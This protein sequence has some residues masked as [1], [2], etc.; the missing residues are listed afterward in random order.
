MIFV[1]S[2]YD[3]H[4]DSFQ[5]E[6][7]EF[8]TRFAKHTSNYTRLVII[9][10]SNQQQNY[11]TFTVYENKDTDNNNSENATTNIH[12]LKLHTLSASNGVEFVNNSTLLVLTILLTLA[13][14]WLLDQLFVSN[15]TPL[16][17]WLHRGIPF[18][19]IFV[20]FSIQMAYLVHIRTS[21]ALVHPEG[22]SG[23]M[24]SGHGWLVVQK[25]VL[26]VFV[27]VRVRVC[28]WGPPQFLK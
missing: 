6:I 18:T 17:T 4:Q 2:E 13:T 20:L 15:H 19:V 10:Y 7:A 27:V 3:S 12:V 5:K 22:C 26:V 16:P 1:N 21:R 24:E 23:T 11:H 25:W 14:V 8:N 28:G 9:H